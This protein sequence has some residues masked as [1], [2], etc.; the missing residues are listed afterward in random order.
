MKEFI[1]FFRKLALEIINF[2]L[3]NRYVFELLGKFKSFDSVFIVYPASDRFAKHFAFVSRL[4]RNKWIPFIVGVAKHPNGSKTLI[5]AISATNDEIMSPNQADNVSHMHER[6]DVIRQKLK[7]KTTHFAGTIPSILRRMLITRSEVERSATVYAVVKAIRE[8]REKLSH[9]N[10]NPVII[11]GNAGYIGKDVFFKLK[12]QHRNVV[13]VEKGDKFQAPSIP[14]LVVNISA[15]E[16]IIDHI[17]SCNQHTTILN[18]VYPAP[19]VSVRGALKQKGVKVFHIN[20][21]KAM[22]FP[23]FP[24]EYRGGLPCCGSIPGIEYEV[25]VTEM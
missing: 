9:T 15:P 20:G 18:E 7:A 8:L 21:V 12:E 10:E 5:L 16:A 2:P 25:L 13:G 19:S 6:V 23:P 4:R 11:I 22:A 24:G 14:H 3:N 1:A 17:A